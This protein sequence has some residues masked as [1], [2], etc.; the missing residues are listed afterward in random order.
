[1]KFALIEGERGAYPIPLMCRVLAVSRSGYYAWR[2]R[3]PSGRCERRSELLRQIRRI[4]E[5]SRRTYGSPRIH[6]E[7]RAQGRKHSRRHIAAVMRQ[8][9]LCAR[10]GRRRRP[11]GGPSPRATP[12][13]NV[14]GRDFR[15]RQLNRVWA[16]DLTYIPTAEGWLYLA[17]MVDLA[18]RRVVGWSMSGRPDPALTVSA[19]DMAVAQRK[20]PRGLLHHSDRGV[21]YSCAAYLERLSHHGLRPSLSR[22]GDCWDNA[23][24][25]SFFHSLKIEW[26]AEAQHRNRREAK[27]AVFEYIE[28]WYNRQRRHS[29]LGYLSPAEYE[30]RL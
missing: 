15:V 17:V 26:L 16:A 11:R 24:V 7:L 1:M 14:L 29:S 2:R 28:V 21:H 13:T 12:I 8:A 6:A 9:G 23:V 30:R 10:A 19:L 22:L 5:A 3:K 20:P 27:Q 25:E 4:Y 18:S